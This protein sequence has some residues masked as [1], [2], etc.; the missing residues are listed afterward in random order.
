MFRVD[1]Q[2]FALP[3]AVVERVLRAVE[4]TPLP[5]APSIVLG[6]IDLHGRILPVLNVRRRFGLPD[7]DLRPEHALLVA[8][9]GQRAVVLTIDEAEGVV[10]ASEE[11]AINAAQIV[12]GLEQFSGVLKTTDGLILIHDPETFLSFDETRALHDALEPATRRVTA[13]RSI[14]PR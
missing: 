4:V 6:A 3:L 9:T 11:M 2:R 7:R 12:P 14:A 10:Q 13:A 8:H 1:G 5:N